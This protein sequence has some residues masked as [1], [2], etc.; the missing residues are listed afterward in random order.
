MWIL[1]KK[2]DYWWKKYGL[3]KTDRATKTSLFDRNWATS[4]KPRQ[5]SRPLRLVWWALHIYI[6][7]IQF[8]LF[9]QSGIILLIFFFNLKILG[10]KACQRLLIF[11]NQYEIFIDVK[12]TKGQRLHYLFLYKEHLFI[13]HCICVIVGVTSPWCDISCC[14]G[15]NFWYCRLWKTQ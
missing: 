10:C 14:R 1:K 3:E 6:W 15:Y 5:R 12:Y 9:I 7:P 4:L 11:L 2:Y 8:F 13:F